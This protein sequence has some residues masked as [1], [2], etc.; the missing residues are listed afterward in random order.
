MNELL[1]M[2]IKDFFISI[3]KWKE[4]E[5]EEEDKIVTDIEGGESR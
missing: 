1:W 2:R 5:E 4:E 3:K